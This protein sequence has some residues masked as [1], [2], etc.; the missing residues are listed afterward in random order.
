[1]KVVAKTAWRLALEQTD[2]FFKNYFQWVTSFCYSILFTL[3]EHPYICHLVPTEHKL[4]HFLRCR[5]TPSRGVVS[6]AFLHSRS[7]S[8]RSLVSIHLTDVSQEVMILPVSKLEMHFS[9]IP[10]CQM[11]NV[12]LLWAQWGM[13]C[14]FCVSSWWSTCLLLSDFTTVNRFNSRAE[15]HRE[16]VCVRVCVWERVSVLSLSGKCKKLIPLSSFISS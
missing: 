10:L 15:L 8:S 6:G 1:M 7:S 2:H 9:T 13:D 3:M 14:R 4:F 5:Q 12:H 11:G 16:C